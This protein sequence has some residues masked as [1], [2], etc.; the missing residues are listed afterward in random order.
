MSITYESMQ[1]K[2][3]ERYLTH[4]V[5]PKIFFLASYTQL[6]Y[7]P[8]HTPSQL[9]STSSVLPHRFTPAC[10]SSPM[11]APHYIALLTYLSLL[12]DHT[13]FIFGFLKLKSMPNTQENLNKS[14]WIDRHKIY[15]SLKKKSRQS[16]RYMATPFG[17]TV[18][19][20]V[21]NFCQAKL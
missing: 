20:G 10:F 8:F 2:H 7:Q 1:V 11:L 21:R 18:S 14:T 9:P 16:D 19:L 17:F 6:E 13:L 15:Q 3:Q 4:A 12:T 5:L